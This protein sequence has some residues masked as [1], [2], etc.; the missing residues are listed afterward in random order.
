MKNNK[1]GFATFDCIVTLFII[2]NIVFVI[3]VTLHNSFN[4]LNKNEKKLKMLTIAKE[5]IEDNRQFIKNSDSEQSYNN[6]KNIENYVIKTSVTNTSF[7]KCYNLKVKVISENNEMELNTY[8]T[9][10]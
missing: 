2:V 10:K 6:S 3:T 8:V 7:Y 5:E 4:L 1:S 9:Q